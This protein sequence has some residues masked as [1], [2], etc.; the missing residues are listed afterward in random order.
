M[1]RRTI[2]HYKG[3]TIRPSRVLCSEGRYTISEASGGLV[4]VG[5]LGA[6]VE[7]IDSLLTAQST[8]RWR[9]RVAGTGRLS[10]LQQ[11]NYWL[12]GYGN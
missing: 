6:A 3:V 2:N 9:S 7:Y 8:P 11:T 10:R 4:L 12:L 5:H 1:K